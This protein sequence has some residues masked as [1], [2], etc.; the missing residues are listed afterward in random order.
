[1]G[2]K[3]RSKARNQKKAAAPGGVAPQP[4]TA[5]TGA[6]DPGQ[7][8]W[9]EAERLLEDGSPQQAEDLLRGLLE[10]VEDHR[11]RLEGLGKKLMDRQ[12]FDGAAAVFRLLTELFPDDPRSY[13]SLSVASAMAGELGQALSAQ[14]RAVEL[15]P[16]SR[17]RRLNLGKLYMMMGDWAL[18]EE[19]LGQALELPGGNGD[20]QIC[21]LLAGCREK[22]LESSLDSGDDWQAPASQAAPGPGPDAGWS[23]PD[24]TIENSLEPWQADP[25]AEEAPAQTIGLAPEPMSQPQPEPEPEPAEA[26]EPRD[27]GKPHKATPAAH[28]LNILFVQEAPCIRNYK[29]AL[30]LRSRGHRV[31]LAYS[32]A[33]LSQMYTG[34]SDEAYDECIQVANFRQLWDMS[35]NYDLL[36]C[37]NE[38]DVMTVAAL[39]GEAP[40]VHDTHDLISLR[41][42]GDQSLGFFEGVA[43]R[44]AGGRVYTTAFQYEE[45]KKLYGVNGR[46]LV[47]SNYASQADLPKRA[48]PKL[49][50][51]DGQTHLVYEGGISQT[52]H[53]DFSELF[54]FLAQNGL[55]IHIYPVRYDPNLAGVFGQ[56]PNIHYHQPASPKDIMEKMTQY[57]VGIIPFNLEKGNRRFLDS[58]QA[59]KLYEYL[60]AGLPVVTSNLATYREFFAQNP[61]G[62][63]FENGEE[64]LAKL[65]GLRQSVQGLDLT[66]FVKTYEGEIQRLEEFYLELLGQKPAQPEDTDRFD[67]VRETD[68][69]LSFA[70]L[71]AS[72][73]GQTEASPPPFSY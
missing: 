20:A 21:N 36:H 72:G 73:P 1:M 52:A 47:F 34:L 10:P 18:A 32:K 13:N 39:A 70:G 31:S 49:S 60:A 54:F 67:S 69:G 56:S 9:P 48:L 12:Q 43:N 24:Q 38:P 3:K 71:P 30:A 65:P 6:E 27:F 44:G 5:S 53:R 19:A 64:I 4:E 33:R 41:A 7:A 23:V 50:A 37:H 14:A 11:Q 8:A 26:A 58:T 29:M 51:A 59:N 16:H 15:E 66:S 22:M 35:K 62:F 68:F 2:K 61:A 17:L 40:V 45:A 55:H 63:T 42:G 57:D 25:P 28:S 46:S